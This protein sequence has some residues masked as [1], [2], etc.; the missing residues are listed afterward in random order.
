MRKIHALQECVFGFDGFERNAS[1]AERRNLDVT[2]D[3]RPL[4]IILAGPNGAGKTTVSPRFLGPDVEFVNA[5]AIGAGS[6]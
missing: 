3:D 6:G 4:A 1:I 2:H 5:D